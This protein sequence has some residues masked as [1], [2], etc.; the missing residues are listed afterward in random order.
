MAAPWVPSLA[1]LTAD[2]R[3][4]SL[5]VYLAVYLAVAKVDEMVVSLAV[6]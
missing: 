5:A 2:E 1:D 3:V 6:A 4:V